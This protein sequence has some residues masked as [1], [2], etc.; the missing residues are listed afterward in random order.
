ML[1]IN[2]KFIILFAAVIILLMI[3]ILNYFNLIPLSKNW[4][5][6]FGWLPHQSSGLGEGGVEPRRTHPFAQDFFVC[7]VWGEQCKDAYAVMNEDRS[8]VIGIGYFTLSPGVEIIAMMDGSYTISR[9]AND[10]EI[11]LTDTDGNIQAVYNFKDP[12]IVANTQPISL[13]KGDLIYK[14][15]ASPPSSIKIFDRD[16][17]YA[18]IVYTQLSDSKSPL[19]VSVD[20]NTGRVKVL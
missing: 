2:F 7:P 4:P 13:L 9:N 20:R 15:D 5:A 8:Q 16:T 6:F 18:L 1:R 19:S 10:V 14:F 3:L 11:I 17:N 12:S